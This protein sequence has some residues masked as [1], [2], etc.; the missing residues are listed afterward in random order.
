MS[1]KYLKKIGIS[2]AETKQERSRQAVKNLVEAAE[3]LVASGDAS[4]LNAREL[5]RIS[6]H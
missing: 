4:N 2:F 1:E 5:S 6:G 3:Y